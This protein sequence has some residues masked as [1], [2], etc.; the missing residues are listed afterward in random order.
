M[1]IIILAEVSTYQ[2]SG[3]AFRILAEQAVGLKKK[4][5]QVG[6]LVRAPPDDSR[7]QVVFNS[8][9]EFRY[10]VCRKSAPA[11]VLSSLSCL[12]AS[13]PSGGSYPKRGPAACRSWP[14]ARAARP[15]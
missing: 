5:Q 15:N 9:P 2:L 3:G 7:P 8:I 13:K 12:P 1:N 11:F 6:L 14:P 4:G 10:V